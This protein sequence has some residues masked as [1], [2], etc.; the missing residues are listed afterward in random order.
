VI[1]VLQAVR[2]LSR[3]AN[4]MWHFCL[5]GA[6]KVKEEQE[7]TEETE[8]CSIQVDFAQR[9]LFSPLSPV[10]SSF[11]LGCGRSQRCD[12]CGLLFYPFL[13]FNFLPAAAF[14]AL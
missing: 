13:D 12:L 5:F 9:P 11:F 14:A 6:C 3:R 4:F 2:I 10:Q 1:S 8:R 7:R